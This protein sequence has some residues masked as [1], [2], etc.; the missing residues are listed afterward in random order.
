MPASA[1]AT[2]ARPDPMNSGDIPSIASRVSGTVNENA[3][4]PTNPH[5]RPACDVRTV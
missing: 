3:T 5:Q 1:A 4:T 2:T